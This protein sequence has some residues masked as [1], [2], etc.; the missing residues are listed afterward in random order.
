MSKSVSMRGLDTSSA[1]KGELFFSGVFALSGKLSRCFG[2]L[3]SGWTVSC[4]L[5]KDLGVDDSGCC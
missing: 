4:L 5:E 3:P 2:G 1:L